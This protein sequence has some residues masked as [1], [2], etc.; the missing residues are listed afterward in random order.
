MVDRIS[1]KKVAL[2]IVDQLEKTE[3]KIVETFKHLEGYVM[4]VEGDQ[5]FIN[6]GTNEGVVKGMNFSISRIKEMVDPVSG[7][8]KTVQMPL[9]DVKIISVQDAVSVGM[10]A[11]GAS[12]GIQPKDHATRRQ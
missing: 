2:N 12:K 3:I 11:G 1:M 8:T 10:V 6:I 9:A 4:G 7:T 5:I